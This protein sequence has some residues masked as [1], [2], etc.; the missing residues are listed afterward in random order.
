MILLP[1][2]YLFLWGNFQLKLFVLVCMCT[3]QQDIF[4]T[5]PASVLV[6]YSTDSIPKHLVGCLEYFFSSEQGTHT[7]LLVPEHAPVVVTISL[8]SYLLRVS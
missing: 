2:G 6:H 7:F 1:S 8:G 4:A 5:S 3:N